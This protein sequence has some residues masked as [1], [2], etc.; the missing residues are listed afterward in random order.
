LQTGETADGR[1]PLVD[2]QHPHDLLMELSATYSVAVSDAG[3]VFVYAAL[4]GEPALGPA[5][6]MHRFSAME[7]PEAPLAHHWLDSTHVAWGVVTGGWAGA[8]WKVEASVFTGR[9]P[10]HNR[11]N[12]ESPRLDSQSVRVTWNPS[13]SWSL[14]ASRGRLHSPEQLEPEVDVERTTASVSYVGSCGDGV[15]SDRW[16]ATLAWGRNGRRPGAT[17]DAWLLEASAQ[18]A[19]A[20]T[21]FARGEHLSDLS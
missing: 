2:R 4:P 21:L 13:P 1:R 12:V 19:E 9:E 17:S 16:G 18:W 11:W 5:T 7:N 6:Y 3:S 20:N 10:D 14:Q 8:A 15:A